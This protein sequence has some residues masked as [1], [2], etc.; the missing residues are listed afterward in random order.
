MAYL[1]RRK[2]RVALNA[3]PYI[4]G[5]TVLDSNYVNDVIDMMVIWSDPHPEIAGHYLA[6]IAA[7]WGCSPKDVF[8]QLQPVGAYI[9]VNGHLPIIGNKMSRHDAWRIARY[10]VDG[11]AR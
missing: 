11:R 9:A 2:Q 6:T 1:A 4:A 5:S 3:Y 8:D 7:E 10:S